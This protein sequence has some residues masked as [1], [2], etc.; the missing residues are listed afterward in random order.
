MSSFKSV[1]CENNTSVQ[2]DV[3]DS[4]C[5]SCCKV[6]FM[7]QTVLQGAHLAAAVC[8]LSPKESVDLQHPPPAL[9]PNVAKHFTPQPCTFPLLFP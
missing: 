8:P 3:G 1:K 4:V 7:P 2:S 5:F 9:Q 6:C